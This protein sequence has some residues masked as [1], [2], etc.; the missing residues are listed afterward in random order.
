VYYRNFY[1]AVD[2]EMRQ[3]YGKGRRV[4]RVLLLT[5]ESVDDLGTYLRWGILTSNRCIPVKTHYTSAAVF[6]ACE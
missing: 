5:E 2:D 6:C 4:S 1:N 3:L